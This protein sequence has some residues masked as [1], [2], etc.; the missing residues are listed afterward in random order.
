M[1]YKEYYATINY[2]DETSTFYGKIEDIDDL[3]SFES[4]NVKGLKNVPIEKIRKKQ[5]M[6][7]KIRYLLCRNFFKELPS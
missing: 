1:K 6:K 5:K 3:I 4:D 2:E 7:I